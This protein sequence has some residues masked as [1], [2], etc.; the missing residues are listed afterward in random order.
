MIAERWKRQGRQERDKELIKEAEKDKELD[1]AVKA[2]VIR[3]LKRST[4]NQEAAP[5][6]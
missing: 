1:Q 4:E 5:R 6:S 2:E 3:F